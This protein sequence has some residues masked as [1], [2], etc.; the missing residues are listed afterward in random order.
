MIL[1]CACGH[2]KTEHIDFSNKPS[3]C[4]HIVGEDWCGCQDFQLDSASLTVKELCRNTIYYSKRD[5]DM[6]DQCDWPLLWEVTLNKD[7]QHTAKLLDARCERCNYDWD[8]ES[9]HE[10]RAMQ[11]NAIDFA[12]NDNPLELD[13]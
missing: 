4:M 1:Y 3:A 6:A 13:S 7:G 2:S 8:S 12:L 11:Q 5:I 9:E 10:F